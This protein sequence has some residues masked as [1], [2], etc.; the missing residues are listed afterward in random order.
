MR[1]NLAQRIVIVIGLAGLLHT[2]RDWIVNRPVQ[3]GWF[4]YAP[5]S[6]MA[7][8]PHGW[9]SSTGDHL[10]TLAFVLVWVLGS[11]WLLRSGPRA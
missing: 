7:F 3:G 10:L 5:S 9:S 2:I 4:N 1:L 8:S 11:V 6:A